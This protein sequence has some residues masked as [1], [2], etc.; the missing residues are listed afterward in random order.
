MTQQDPL[1]NFRFR[2][3]IDSLQ[4]AGFSEVRI[5]AT[6]TDVIEYREGNEPAYVRKLTGLHKFGNVTL[7]RGVTGSLELYNWHRQIL[8]GQT[9]GA[10]RS[11]VIVVA[12]EAGADQAR[13]TVR[14]AWPVKYESS[15]LNA[16]GTEVL[17]ETLELANEGIER[18]S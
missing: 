13:F 11:V 14:N 16:Q 7:K 3:E 5:G 12:D 1:R 17:I 10:R 15:D 9:A 6:T 4:V 18:E 2:V 8:M